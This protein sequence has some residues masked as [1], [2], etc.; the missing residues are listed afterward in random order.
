MLI[1]NKYKSSLPI[2]GHKPCANLENV[3]RLREHLTIMLNRALD[4]WHLFLAL[5]AKSMQ[6]LIFCEGWQGDR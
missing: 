2:H 4:S 1:C 6:Y 3:M 5:P